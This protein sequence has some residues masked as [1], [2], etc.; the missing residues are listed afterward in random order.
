MENNIVSSQVGTLLPLWKK[1][2]EKEKKWYKI[3]TPLYLEHLF[4]SCVVVH[5][6]DW[7][8]GLLDLLVGLLGLQ[9]L[10]NKNMFNFI[11][12]IRLLII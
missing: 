8:H 12:Y 5:Y 3:I 1:K 11:S 4:S 7:T 10:A 9:K 6:T 2:K